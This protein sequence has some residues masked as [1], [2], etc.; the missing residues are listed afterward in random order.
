M[1]VAIA[2]SGQDV[3]ATT[4]S[5]LQISYASAANLAEE[6]PEYGDQ[7]MSAAESSFLEGDQLAYVAG[8]VAVIIGAAVVL[9]FF[10]RKDEEEAM[11]LAFH[12]EDEGQ[13][14]TAPPPMAGGRQIPPAPSPQGSPRAT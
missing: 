8:L 5:E 4:Q 13:D 14:A 1:G 3:T 10:P 2:D 9:I 12:A 7:I 11:R 6:Y